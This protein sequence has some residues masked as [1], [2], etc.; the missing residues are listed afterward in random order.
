MIGERRSTRLRVEPG[1]VAEFRAAVGLSADADAAVAPPTFTAVMEH[2]GPTVISLLTDRGID[3]DTV[4]HGEEDISYPHGPLRV[5][6]DLT[7]EI[8]ITDVRETSGAS[9]P[10]RIVTVRTELANAAGETVVSIARKLV[11]LDQ[12]A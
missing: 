11:I 5:G 8:E 12:P 1:K 3:I 10:L 6:D 7:G 2:F 4:L 9:G